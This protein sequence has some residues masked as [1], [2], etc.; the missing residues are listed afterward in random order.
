MEER[1]YIEIR[2]D[3]FDKSLSPKDVDINEIK[4]IISDIETFLY[5]TKEEKYSRPLISYEIQPGSA[6]HKFFLP[7]SSVI[8]FAGLISEVSKRDSIG[9]LDYKRQDIISKF[10]R[11]AIKDSIT[12]EFNTSLSKDTV[13]M[14]NNNT[15]FEME[16]PKY[17]EAEFYLYGEIYQEGGKSPN[18]HINT[19][20]D[21]NLAIS[22]TKEQITEGEKKT[23]KTY[24]V[25]VKGKKSLEDGRLYDLK[26]I[27]FI[28]YKPSFDRVL[29]DKMI[30]KASENLSKIKDLDEWID[31]LKAENI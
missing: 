27:D 26:L 8:L 28:Q 19:L 18:V 23:Y 22:A 5:P 13:L 25:K 16:S 17:Y 14:V 9:F 20:K 21:G 10:Q 7:I 30:S 29:L 15:R 4:N 1:G 2:I 12:I 24:G 31:G 3:N 11:K 6:K